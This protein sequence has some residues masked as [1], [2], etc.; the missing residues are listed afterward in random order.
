MARLWQSGFELNSITGDVEFSTISGTASISSTTVRTGGFAGRTNPAAA[1]GFFR[2][3]IFAADSSTVVFFR[4][5]L[6]IAAAP[7]AS[8][9]VM[10]I[11]NNLDNACAQLQLTSTRT[12]ILL[13][14]AATQVGSPSAVLSLNQWYRVE[15]KLDASASPGTLDARVDGVSFA[16]GANSAQSPW[17][18]VIVGPVTAATTCDLFWDDLAVNDTTGTAQNSWPDDGQII[19]LVPNADGDAHAWGDTTNVAG[20]TNNFTLVDEVPPNDA[21]DLVQ[22][23]TLNAEDMYNVTDPALGSAVR[24]NCVLV[25]GRHRNNTADATTAFRYQLKKASGGTVQQSASIIPNSTTFTTNANAQPR[26]YPIVAHNDPDGLPWTVATLTSM[27]IGQK[28]TAAGTNRVQVTAVWASV[29]VTP[30]AK[31]AQIVSPYAGF[32]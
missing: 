31:T 11:S 7:G 32:F 21:T 18:K 17:R 24:I 30:L 5:Y 10:R 15:L 14:A 28:L 25:G 8:T 2:Q 27:Q 26:N 29:D 20:T 9:V 16:A 4:A 1:T 19:N 6:R 23:V 3:V 22:S 13:N 12:L